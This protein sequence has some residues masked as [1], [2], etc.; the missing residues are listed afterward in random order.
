MLLCGLESVAQEIFFFLDSRSLGMSEV[1]DLSSVRDR[2]CKAQNTSAMNLRMNDSGLEVLLS[3]RLLIVCN[4]LSNI[5]Q[6]HIQFIV[7]NYLRLTE[8]SAVPTVIGTMIME[9]HFKW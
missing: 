5:T 4:L 9:T 7:N 2:F 8:V 6:L 1:R 3:I